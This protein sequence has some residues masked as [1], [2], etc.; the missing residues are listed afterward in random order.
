MSGTILNYREE[1]NSWGFLEHKKGCTRPGRVQPFF[2]FSLGY[3]LGML[4]FSFGAFELVA[5]YE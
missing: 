4:R 1:G 5:D 3:Y 2:V